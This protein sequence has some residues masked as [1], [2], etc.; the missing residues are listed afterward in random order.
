MA[1]GLEPISQILAAGAAAGTFATD[2]PDF[3]ANRLYT[4]VLGTMHLARLQVGVRRG[5]TGLGEAFAIDPE[6]LR[7]ACVQDA[8]AL[9]HGLR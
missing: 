3:T 1:A 5:P 8:M 7:A 4:Q 9:A 2:D 6:Q